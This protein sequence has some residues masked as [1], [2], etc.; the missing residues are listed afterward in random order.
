VTDKRASLSD[1]VA[2]HVQPGD[3]ICL[4]TGH[5]RWTAGARELVRQ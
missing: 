3:A 1:A 2:A 5:T 4:V